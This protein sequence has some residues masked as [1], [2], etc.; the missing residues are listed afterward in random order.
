MIRNKI[1][2]DDFDG[3]LKFKKKIIFIKLVEDKTT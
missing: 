1:H 2:K 3:Y